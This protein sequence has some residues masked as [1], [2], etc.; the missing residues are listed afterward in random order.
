VAGR[1]NGVV[2]RAVARGASALVI[3]PFLLAGSA[4]APPH[5]HEQATGHSHAFVHS[6]FA[7]HHVESHEPEGAE[8]EPGT[9]HVVWLENAILHQPSFQTYAPPPLIASTLD[10]IAVGSSWS[11]TPFDDVAPVH[12]PPRPHPSFRGPP[13]ALA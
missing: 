13:L 1:H 4:L 8:F 5:A 9:E 7:P 2:C 3:A 6:H 12:G 11:P 10:A